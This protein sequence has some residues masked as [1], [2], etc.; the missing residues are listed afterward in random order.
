MLYYFIGSFKGDIKADIPFV[1]TTPILKKVPVSQA[2]NGGVNYKPKIL[3]AFLLKM[4]S[5]SESVIPVSSNTAPIYIGR[6][7]VG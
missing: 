6:L 3:F 4:Y 5:F 7:Q 2:Q 1:Y